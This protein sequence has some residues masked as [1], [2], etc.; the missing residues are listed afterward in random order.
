M[1]SGFEG[2][3]AELRRVIREQDHQYLEEHPELAQLFA[4][5]LAA[6][7]ETQPADLGAFTEAYFSTLSTAVDQ[8]GQ[9]PLMIIGPSGC[10][11]VGRCLRRVLSTRNFD[12]STRASSNFPSRTPRD[13]LAKERR[14]A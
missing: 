1:E 9:L 7:A 8:E 6:L 13:H 2:I 12:D 11:K 14:T 3:V 4:D 10:G 5:Y